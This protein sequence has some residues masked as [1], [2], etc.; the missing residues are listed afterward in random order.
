MSVGCRKCRELLSI[1][2][3]KYNIYFIYAFL[4]STYTKNLLDTL[5]NA[6]LRASSFFCLLAEHRRHGDT[7]TRRH[8]DMEI[9]RY[10]DM[11]T[12]RHGD[13]GHSDTATQ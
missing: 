1:I 10:G 12:W 11:E 4:I 9:W 3:I 2:V 8:G 7:E 5:Y 13:M 6:S